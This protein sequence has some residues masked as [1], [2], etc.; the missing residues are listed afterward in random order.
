MANRIFQSLVLQMKDSVDCTVGV[1]DTEGN[2]V[3]CSELAWMGEQWS[4]AVAALNSANAPQ[5]CYE[6]K[7]FKPLMGW[8]AQFDY[9]AFVQGEDERAAGLCAMAAVANRSQRSL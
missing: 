4:G 6:G 2:V 8:G 3:A 7:T 5:V 1:I 9:A